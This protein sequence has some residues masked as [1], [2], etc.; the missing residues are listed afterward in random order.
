MSNSL[1]PYRGMGKDELILLA[2]FVPRE[3]YENLQRTC[4]GHGD[5]AGYLAYAYA[6]LVEQ[7]KQHNLHERYEPSNRETARRLAA[8]VFYR[9]VV[10]GR[11]H[12][13]ERRGTSSPCSSLPASENQSAG[14]DTDEE[15]C[16][17]KS[18]G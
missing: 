10:G 2:V 14:N 12:Q 16:G 11:P 1:S 4:L 15:N 17:E 13:D 18:D 9:G 8:G 7:F 3:Q 5:M 6:N